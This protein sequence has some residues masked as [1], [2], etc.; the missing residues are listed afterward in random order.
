MVNPVLSWSGGRPT[1]TT[2]I[3]CTVYS[4]LAI[5]ATRILQLIQ[6][7]VKSFSQVGEL[8]LL[9]PVFLPQ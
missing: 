9:T 7:E 2:V 6:P 3:V 8:G 1:G 5:N 4:A